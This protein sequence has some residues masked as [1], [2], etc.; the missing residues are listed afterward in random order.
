MSD[1][2][3]VRSVARAMQL[4]RALQLLGEASLATLQRRT[5]LPKPTLLRLLHT[6]EAESAVWRARGD[7]LWRPAVHFR[8][9][10][11]LTPEH[12]RLIEVAMPLLEATRERLVWPSDLAVR[13]DHQMV[14]LETT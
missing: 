10:R 1:E 4:L 5:E 12:Q 9:T 14:L 13:V 6:L 11:I 2:G 3:P 7:G 8:P